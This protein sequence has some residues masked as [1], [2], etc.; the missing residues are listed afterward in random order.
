MSMDEIRVDDIRCYKIFSAPLDFKFHTMNELNETVT[1]NIKFTSK[2]GASQMTS[3]LDYEKLS[4][5]SF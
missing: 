4:G 5:T 1:N 3:K 2:D